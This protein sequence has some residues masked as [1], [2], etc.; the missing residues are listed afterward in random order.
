MCGPI[1]LPDLYSKPSAKFYWAL[2]LSA[3]F[4]LLPSTADHY[5]LSAWY[6]YHVKIITDT[7][8]TLYLYLEPL[9]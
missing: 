9:I 5:F 8:P 7:F 3:C 1:D 6:G 4:V 2:F